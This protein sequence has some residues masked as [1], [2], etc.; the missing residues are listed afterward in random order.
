[1]IPYL[2]LTTGRRRR[3]VLQ[4]PISFYRHPDSGQRI[5]V[6]AT[7]HYAEPAYYR[8][9][10]HDIDCYQQDGYVVHYENAQ[11]QTPGDEP[12]QAEQSVLDDLNALRDLETVR[13]AP[14]GWVRQ[15]SLLHH[16]TWQRKDL[17]DLDVIRQAGTD[18]MT[19]YLTT[20]RA[21]FDWPDQQVWRLSRVYA[22]FALSTR[23]IASSAAKNTVPRPHRDPRMR[24]VAQVLT[25]TRTALAL[26]AAVTTTEDTVMIWGAAHLP[27]IH[28]GLT[29]AGHHLDGDP[30]WRT[31]GYLPSIAAS[32]LRYLLRQPPAMHPRYHHATPAA[33]LGPAPTK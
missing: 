2:Q 30:Q 18:A 8:E 20:R 21:L 16:P 10:L 14:L 32:A 28:T 27:G 24:A 5:V 7:H 11:Y 12:T 31:V 1:M 26:D 25:D 33:P 17:T 6:V 9:L 3:L 13:M 22:F 23:L 15:P 29:A 19:H 4:T